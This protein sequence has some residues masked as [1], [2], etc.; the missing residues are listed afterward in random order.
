MSNTIIPLVKKLCTDSCKEGEHT[1]TAVAKFY[2]TLLEN[3]KPELTVEDSMWF[4]TFYVQL[5]KKGL[6]FGRDDLD[7]ETSLVST[8]YSFCFLLECY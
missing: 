6:T 2:G 3:L 7:I 5:A 1:F 4:F 8:F